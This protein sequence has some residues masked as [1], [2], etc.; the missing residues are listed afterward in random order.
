METACVE[1]NR[2]QKPLTPFAVWSM[3]TTL[4]RESTV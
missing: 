1:R 4:L 3:L 2:L